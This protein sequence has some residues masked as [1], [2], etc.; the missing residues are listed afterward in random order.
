MSIADQLLEIH[1]FNK[2]DDAVRVKYIRQVVSDCTKTRNLILNCYNT[3]SA[4]EACALIRGMITTMPDDQLYQ[5][6]FAPNI[7]F[8]I[9]ERAM[10]TKRF[11]EMIAEFAYNRLLDKFLIKFRNYLLNEEYPQGNR[12]CEQIMDAI[13]KCAY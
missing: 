1:R 12:I 6:R 4:D 13:D 11:D 3:F 9:M 7:F 5:L 2:S 8:T 10:E